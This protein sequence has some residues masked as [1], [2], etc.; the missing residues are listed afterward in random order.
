MSDT[1]TQQATPQL[2]A[3]ARERLQGLRSK[4]HP[5]AVF[6]SDLSVNEFL[7]VRKA[8]FEPI[9]LCVGSSI[10]HVGI[11]YGAWNKNQELEVLSQA[12]Y[13]ARELAMSRMREEARE[14][15]AHGIV[16]VRLDIKHV[17]WDANILEFVAIGTGVVH[18]HEREGFRAHDG[19]PFTSDLSG[20]DFYTLL[21]AGYRPIELVMGSCVYHVAHRG[22]LKAWGQAL[23]N[24]ELE[25]F[26]QAIYSARELAIERMQVEAQTAKAEGVIGTTIHEKSY[27]WESHVIE[28]FAIG[29]AVTPLNAEI[30]AKDIPAPTFVLSVN[31]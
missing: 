25:E 13:H 12:M 15:G 26:T 1:T 17:E 6:T 5:T 9:G 4:A 22:L 28:F 8:G 16:G 20:Q 29:T 7:L 10:Y 19:G 23:R 18:H 14:M 3:T 21:N 11:Q 24:V 2:P 27:R 30:D 31:D